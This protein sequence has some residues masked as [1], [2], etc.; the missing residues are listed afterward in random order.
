MGPVTPVSRPVRTRTSPS[1]TPSPSSS[2][3][4][5]SSPSPLSSPLSSPGHRRLAALGLVL[6]GSV[7]PAAATAQEVVLGNKTAEWLVA[8]AALAAPESLRDGAEVR[9]WT[10]DDHLVTLRRG[11]NDIIC[12][13]DRPGD[14]TFA[15]ACYH[16]SLEAFMERGRE[17]SRQGVA[18]GERNEVRWR[19]IRE[20]A[21]PM[22]V[23]AMVYNLRFPSE[24][25]D[26]ATV[27][28]ATGGRLHAIYMPDATPESTGLPARP[29][30]GPWLM[31]PGTPSAHVMIGLPVKG[32]D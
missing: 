14:D 27:D 2:P 20:G 3:L 19:E 29:G 26:P 4:S 1:P 30:D 31:L 25:F 15:A 16:A 22:P 5:T 9:G 17:L 7:L 11:A 6:A 13:A 24:D 10:A 23:A 21:I 18:G 12:L 28:P 8:S 32:G